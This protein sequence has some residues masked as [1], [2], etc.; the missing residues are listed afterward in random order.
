MGGTTLLI[1][2]AI[3]SVAL[4]LAAM[5]AVIIANLAEE[6]AFRARLAGVL[7]RSTPLRV[8]RTK[9]G[10]I[11]LLVAPFLALG[12]RLRHTALFQDKELARFERAVTAFGLDGPS[13]VQAFV[14]GKLVLLIAL[15]VAGYLL[16]QEMG[17]A[18]LGALIGAFVGLTLAIYGSAVVLRLVAGPYEAQLRK[19]LPDAL[20]LMVVCAE[21]GLGLETAVARV[22][23]E[24]GTSNRPIAHEFSVLSY[25]LRVLPDRREA[26][27]RFASRSGFESFR[28]VAATLAQTL[29]YGTPL[30]QALR[31]LAADMRTQRLMKIEEKAV[32]LPALLT[33]PMIFFMLPALFIALGAPSFVGML[34][35][36]RQ[37]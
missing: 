28:Q 36:L 1:G 27:E 32:R 19:G 4:L 13:M 35:Y 8:P 10:L 37:Q 31:T 9:E 15:P 5:V 18:G 14:G 22:A 34:A 23:K 30:A 21:A 6:R 26:L 29:R 20:D 3:L 7:Q 17:L 33:F 25:E 12:Q 16:A 2:A 24:M 11:K